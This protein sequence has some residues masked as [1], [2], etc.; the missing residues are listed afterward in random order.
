MFS[1]MNPTASCKATVDESNATVMVD[2]A[3][4]FDE[5]GD[6]P[7]RDEKAR[8]DNA[9]IYMQKDVPQSVIY[10]LI[11][12]GSRACP[13]EARERGI[14][15]KKHLMSRGVPP[16]QVV[17]IDGGYRREISTT[18]WIWPPAVAPP[19]ASPELTLKPSEVKIE[20]N[21]KIKYRGGR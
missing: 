17:W 18:V 13:G 14:R 21:C 20:R 9:A 5:W 16:G 4:P 6:I 3:T 15:A 7:F 1:S 12:A 2:V 11:Y 10:L 19:V 8:L